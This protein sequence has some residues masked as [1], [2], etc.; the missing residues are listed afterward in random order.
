MQTNPACSS[1]KLAQKC[2]ES[3]LFHLVTQNPR[4]F[5]NLWAKSFTF[6]MALF[7]VKSQALNPSGRV[8]QPL[9]ECSQLRVF[10]SLRKFLF[11]CFLSPS[12]LFLSICLFAREVPLHSTAHPDLL[13]PMTHISGIMWCLHPYQECFGL[14]CIQTQP[15]RCQEDTH[16][17]LRWGLPT[18]FPHFNIQCSR[19]KQFRS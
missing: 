8:C 7:K 5:W 12:I 2:E 19:K 11:S 15:M 1:M 6:F 13:L 4:P 9:Q 16:P 17:S 14:C 3:L 10:Y 18:N